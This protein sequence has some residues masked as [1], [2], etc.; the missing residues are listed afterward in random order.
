MKKLNITPQFLVELFK[1]GNIITIENKKEKYKIDM[2]KGI[3]S[4]LKVVGVQYN[5]Y[6]NMIEILFDEVNTEDID[7]VCKKVENER[8]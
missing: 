1:E 8:N 2:Q 3:T 6:T 4:N 7:I 5:D